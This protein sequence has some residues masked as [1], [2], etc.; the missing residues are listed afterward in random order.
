MFILEPRDGFTM[1]MTAHNRRRLLLNS[2]E[3]TPPLVPLPA[4]EKKACSPSKHNIS[5]PSLGQTPLRCAMSEARNNSD[6]FLALL[7][8][9][10][11]L[12]RVYPYF[13]CRTPH[14]CTGRG[15]D[16]R[17]LGAGPPPVKPGGGGR[18]NNGAQYRRGRGAAGAGGR[19]FG[20]ARHGMTDDLRHIK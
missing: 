10:T 4:L 16:Q 14:R 5:H 8:S 19:R 7:H 17:R 1:H 6:S 11:T 18:R 13:S 12:Y 20:C 15:G 2:K 3:A 9:N